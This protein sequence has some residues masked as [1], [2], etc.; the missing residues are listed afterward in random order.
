MKTSNQKPYIAE[1]HDIG[2][3]AD[4][5]A[6]KK[7]GLEISGHTYHNFDFK[8]LGIPPPISPSWWGQ[9]SDSIKS[10]VAVSGL[11]S[12]ITDEGR[13]YVMLTKIADTIAACVSRPWGE[14]GEDTEGVR[15]LWRP[16]F[17]NEMR[18][19]GR[20]WAAFS[21]PDELKTMFDFIDRCESPQE[22]FEGYRDNLLLTAEDKSVPFNC[23]PLGTHL[24]LT[25]RIFRVLCHWS[26]LVYQ[27]SNALLEYDGQRIA[28]VI[29]AAGNRATDGENR[30]KWVFRLVACHIR[31]PQS[32]VRLQDLNVLRLRRQKIEEIIQNQKVDG[33]AERQAY[34]VLFHTDDYLC[35]FLPKETQ[36][37]L[38]QAMAPLT[39]E[40]FWLDYEEL[41]A[42]LNLLTSTGAG[43]RQQLVDRYGNRE[44]V[45]E[46]RYFELRH[47]SLWPELAEEVKTPLCDICQQRQGE[48]H[49][50]NQVSEW[51]CPMCSKMRNL[52]EPVRALSEWSESAVWLKVSLDQ[53]LLLECLE[54]LF[55]N[56][57]DNGSG[58]ANVAENDR[59]AL[60][61]A[62]RPLAAQTEFVQQYHELLDAFQAS[63][64]SMNS[65]RDTVLYPI[66]EYKE[67]AVILTDQTEIPFLAL[68]SFL[69]LLI[70]RFPECL[71]DCPIRL[72]ASVSN[73]KF[74]Y[75]AHWQFF[76]EQQ[77]AGV[78]F[79]IQQPRV[80]RTKLRAQQFQALRKML[81]RGKFSHF[82]HR[83]AA[84]ESEAGELMSMIEALN[85][86]QEFPQI[87]ALM[88]DYGLTFS[89][90]LDF[91]RLTET[92][93]RESTAHA[94]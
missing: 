68:D 65:I 87:Q 13:A 18:Q 93:K 83:L 5:E 36:L 8:Q 40:G 78:I 59:E 44:R 84:V 30:G 54:R 69:K 48:L 32:L 89:Q 74:P 91:H 64:H 88:K 43:T 58:M 14:K 33:D 49:L 60:K 17:Y 82:L 37:P 80:R 63:L 42:E 3:L 39:A 55:G 66:P 51:L 57:V 79:D 86:R 67:L 10:L 6:L 16:N 28:A 7:A 1:L 41:E 11:P 45:R 62:F 20:S 29:Q 61:E 4:T 52:G 71:E 2:K 90:I 73:I 76:E 35:L 94:Q 25:G 31:F 75:H 12:G 38:K 24:D 19:R 15:P 72:S 9:W 53:V 70:E 47:R 92:D 50:K 22:F 34:A 27:N 23:I 77:E 21:T 85:R 81:K 56:Y 46:R 26:E